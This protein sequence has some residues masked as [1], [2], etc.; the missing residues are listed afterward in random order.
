MPIDAIAVGVAFRNIAENSRNTKPYDPC[1]TH[2]VM[3]R[4]TLDPS[5]TNQFVYGNRADWFV[6]AAIT[7]KVDVDLPVQTGARRFI[8][9][10]NAIAITKAASG[11]RKQ[12]NGMSLY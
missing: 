10:S 2:Y 12:N 8:P 4:E 7:G 1:I 6:S 5:L 9:L 11:K 3:P